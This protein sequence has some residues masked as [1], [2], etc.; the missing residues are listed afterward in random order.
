MAATVAFA[1]A[2]AS[3]D[4]IHV[5][6]RLTFLSA[7]RPAAKRLH[8]HHREILFRSQEHEA[9]PHLVIAPDAGDGELE[10]GHIDKHVSAVFAQLAVFIVGELPIIVTRILSRR[11]HIHDF[12]RPERHYRLEQYA[13]DQRENGRVNADRQR[14][15]QYR[16]DGETRRLEKLPYSKPEILHHKDPSLFSLR[17]S[18]PWLWI[19]QI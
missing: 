15:R 17:C 1:T 12:S 6:I 19:Q 5:P 11:E 18:R 13:I 10:C 9:T 3:H 16:D 8:A 4:Y 2:L 7:R 14:E